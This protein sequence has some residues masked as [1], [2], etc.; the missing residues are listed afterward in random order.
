MPNGTSD[1]DVRRALAALVARENAEPEL[2]PE[3]GTRSW[4]HEGRTR[5]AVV[6]LHGYTNNPRQFEQLGPLLFADGHNVLAPCFPYHGYRDRMTPAVSAPRFGDWARC[7]LTAVSLAAG[8]GDR[9][10]VVGISVSGTIAAWLAA[11]VA[12]D[13]AIAVSP[14]TGARFLPKA[15]NDGLASAMR[16]LP[17]QRVWWDPTR[18]EAMLPLHAYPRFSTRA[19]GDTLRFV[20]A[21]GPGSDAHAR[22][23]DLVLNTHDPIV[24]NGLAKHFFEPLRDRGVDVTTIERSDFAHRHD[25]IESTLPGGP[26]TKAYELIRYRIDI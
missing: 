26:D 18:E 9:V 25:L 13:S 14:F 21:L 11:Q 6:L 16:R 22:R 8:L 1:S 15:V 3:N 12:I 10:V 20:Y 17:D 7:A 24:N 4:L 23:L 19:L 2:D 5:S